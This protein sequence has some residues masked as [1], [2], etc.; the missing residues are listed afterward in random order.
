M[1]TSIPLLY[2]YAFL[3]LREGQAPYFINHIII[4]IFCKLPLNEKEFFLNSIR[5]YMENRGFNYMSVLFDN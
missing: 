1:Y 3:L 2:Y 4:I 5:N